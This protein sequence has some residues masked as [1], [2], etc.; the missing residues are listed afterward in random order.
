MAE[1]KNYCHP[2]LTPSTFKVL[3]ENPDLFLG[4]GVGRA[5]KNGSKVNVCLLYI[6]LEKMYKIFL[7]GYTKD[8]GKNSTVQKE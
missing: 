7:V 4:P 5:H 1:P 2:M 8:R 3:P 6:K